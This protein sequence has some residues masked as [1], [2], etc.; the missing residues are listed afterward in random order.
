MEFFALALQAKAKQTAPSWLKLPK[1]ASQ[2]KELKIVT[3]T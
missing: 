3:V 2:R 1:K